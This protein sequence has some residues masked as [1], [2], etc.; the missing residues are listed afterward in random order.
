MLETPAFLRWLQALGN[1]I[2]RSNEN[3]CFRFLWRSRGQELLVFEE[4]CVPA[5][6]RILGLDLEK[7][8]EEGACS[9]EHA[10]LVGSFTPA[11]P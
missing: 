1:V 7:F 5:T 3:L 2:L 10:G 11:L 4:A 6:G 9:G 8:L